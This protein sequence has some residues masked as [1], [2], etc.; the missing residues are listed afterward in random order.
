[1][2]IAETNIKDVESQNHT[3][4]VDD[5]QSMESHVVDTKETVQRS[6]SRKTKKGGASRQEKVPGP[7]AIRASLRYVFAEG[8]IEGTAA[9]YALL[10]NADAGVL[11]ENM[12]DKDR[13][14]ISDYMNLGFTKSPG[15]KYQDVCDYRMG[16]SRELLEM[17]EKFFNLAQYHI[18]VKSVISIAHDKTFIN[19]YL[20]QKN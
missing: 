5:K 1:M 20:Y 2:N 18:A 8:G 14:M 12:T 13:R 16:K 6:S 7:K 4:K 10:Q 15:I 9:L 3:Q 11:Y 19:N 17:V